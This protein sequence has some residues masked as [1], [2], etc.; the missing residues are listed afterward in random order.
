MLFSLSPLLCEPGWVFNK[1]VFRGKSSSPIMTWGAKHNVPGSCLS[2]GTPRWVSKYFPSLNV[3]KSLHRCFFHTTLMFFCFWTTC[4]PTDASFCHSEQ[5]FSLLHLTSVL[6]LLIDIYKT[7]GAAYLMEITRTRTSW[8]V[9]ANIL[10]K[11]SQTADEGWS[12]S[13]GLGEV[14]T[15]PPREKHC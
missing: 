11:Q 2:S 8:R 9:A 5:Y 1:E 6:L 15:T 3:Q 7:N 14:L 10:T 13:L 4:D 12:S